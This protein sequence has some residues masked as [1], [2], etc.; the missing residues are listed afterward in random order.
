MKETTKNELKNQLIENITGL[1]N[2]INIVDDETMNDFSFL[3]VLL[4]QVCN[5]LDKVSTDDIK[6]YEYIVKKHL[7][8]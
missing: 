7:L 3:S 5:D 8:D 1:M 6:K 2:H 4:L